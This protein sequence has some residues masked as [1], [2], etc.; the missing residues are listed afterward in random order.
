MI[1]TY[2]PISTSSIF[3]ILAFTNLVN[4]SV[5]QTSERPV[6]NTFV[7]F[8]SCLQCP[9]CVL[10][11]MVFSHLRPPDQSYTWS[12]F[13]L[14]LVTSRALQPMVLFHVML[15]LIMPYLSFLWAISHVLHLFPSE[16]AME[17]CSVPQYGPV[18]M[19]T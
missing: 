7:V 3:N 8:L 13:C 16:Y 15:L 14:R 6:F 19:F 10:L 9:F 17:C 2:K 1:L 18:P 11:A 12:S 4:L 5:K